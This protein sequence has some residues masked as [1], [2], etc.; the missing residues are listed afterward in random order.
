MANLV[1]GNYRQMKGQKLWSDIPKQVRGGKDLLKNRGI[2]FIP[3]HGQLVH[4]N[5]FKA[6]DRMQIQ[7][8]KLCWCGKEG[9]QLV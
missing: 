2:G 9:G 6:K 8:V 5:K 3:R 7:V 4:G 1:R